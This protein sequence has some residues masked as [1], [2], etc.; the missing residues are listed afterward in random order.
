M[1][2]FLNK[3]VT[4]TE[5]QYK[6][7]V[8]LNQGLGEILAQAGPTDETPLVITVAEVAEVL[9]KRLILKG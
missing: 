7:A 4:L 5:G 6:L 8:V 2:E 3:S 1:L 9:G